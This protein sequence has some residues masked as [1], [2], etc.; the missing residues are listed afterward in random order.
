[1]Q[2]ETNIWVR[3]AVRERKAYHIAGMEL[4]A[5]IGWEGQS[6]AHKNQQEICIG[7]VEKI[8]TKTT[9]VAAGDVVVLA[10]QNGFDVEIE[11]NLFLYQKGQVLAKIKDGSLIGAMGYKAGFPITNAQA[12]DAGLIQKSSLF[13]G[14]WGERRFVDG[15]NAYFLS[16][17]KLF[18][19]PS[20]YI[21]QQVLDLEDI[22]IEKASLPRVLYFVDEE[23]ILGV[24]VDGEYDFEHPDQ[25]KY[26]SMELISSEE[27][28]RPKW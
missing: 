9:D 5:P 26:N 12:M 8:G 2:I 15:K 17:R 7:V 13:L 11:P 14:D 25:T 10:Y 3:K 24:E 28:R 22:G 20:N 19:V 18:V 1:M 21:G 27:A 23:S 16:D 4:H 6:Q